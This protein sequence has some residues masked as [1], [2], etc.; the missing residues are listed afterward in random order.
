MVNE[1]TSRSGLSS[2]WA[3]VAAS[4]TTAPAPGRALRQTSSGSR[5]ASARAPRGGR[6]TGCRCSRAPG[7][8]E[9]AHQR[10]PGDRVH[11]H[12]EPAVEVR[13]RRRARRRP[14]RESSRD[15][16][17]DPLLHRDQAL[18]QLVVLGRGDP[19]LHRDREQR[20]REVL[21]EQVEQRPQPGRAIAGE[22]AR[23]L[24]VALDPLLGEVLEGAGDEVDA[25]REVVAL[26]ALRDAGEL[27]HA[28]DRR[29]RVADL[30]QALDRRVEQPAA[31]LGAALGLAARRRR[32]RALWPASTRA[33]TRPPPGRP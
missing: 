33:L 2:I 29:A 25:V 7:R 4:T 5:R 27:G 1:E 26:G 12:R 18:A 17:V 3:W 31:G 30:D 28:A 14:R 10:Q 11:R 6:A 21:P 15:V 9:L 19:E 32:A 24:A 23:P 16:G 20:A 22:L 8:I 13:A